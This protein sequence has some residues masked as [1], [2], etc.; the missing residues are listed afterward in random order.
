MSSTLVPAP[1]R[2][3][4]LPPRCVSD[5]RDALRE[6]FR[7][8]VLPVE[9]R[10]VVYAYAEHRYLVSATTGISEAGEPVNLPFDASDEQLGAAVLDQLLQCYSHPQS[11]P[12][13]RLEDWPV[14]VA[15][16]AK[17]G[18]EFESKCTY[19]TVSTFGGSALIVEAKRRQPPSPLY[20]GRQLGMVGDPGTLGHAVRDAVHALRFLD[21]HDVI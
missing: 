7:H 11:P 10:A 19:V 14:F 13:G 16:G 1:G 6:A 8:H 18:R 15:S 17:S 12:T 21:A 20:V 5:R 3:A 9:L 4:D 2:Y